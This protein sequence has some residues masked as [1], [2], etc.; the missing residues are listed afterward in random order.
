M[1]SKHKAHNQKHK[2]TELPSETAT[3]PQTQKMS[4]HKQT[5]KSI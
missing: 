1:L 4:S 3:L 2:P 5:I